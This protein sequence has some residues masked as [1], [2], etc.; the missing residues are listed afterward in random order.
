M[1]EKRVGNF[2]PPFFK[3]ASLKGGTLKKELLFVLPNDTLEK[4]S[5]SVRE[6]RSG[7]SMNILCI[8]DIVGPAA[9]DF[10]CNNLWKIRKEYDISLTV[11]NG[12][13]ADPGNGITQATAER[14]LTS[15]V[16]VI[17]SGN[18]IWQKSGIYPFLDDCKYILRPA[19]YPASNPGHGCVIVEAD[20]LRVL[21]I[22]LQGLVY[23][24]PLASPF[25]TVDAILKR[26]AGEYDL[27]ILDFHAEATSEKAILAHYLDGRVDVVCGTHTHVQTADE[28][29]LPGGTA[30][31][32][33]L[34]MCG[35][36]NSALGI[37]YEPVMQKLR[38]G[39]P[40][41]FELAAGPITMNSVIFVYNAQKSRVEL[42]K[43]VNFS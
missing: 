12:E 30:F 28:R 39:M 25:D 23:L 35:V 31:I 7:H 24:E 16:D 2:C 3:K 18:H 1:H 32:T 15:G 21:V 8:G 10:V 17:T 41:R 9:A 38:T 34:G 33:D 26:H 29:I 13:N 42:V 5:R 6:K 37:R 27:S 43:R 14:L 11:A 22:N 19:N 20:G 4:D 40:Q 36:Q